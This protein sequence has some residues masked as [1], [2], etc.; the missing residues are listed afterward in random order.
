MD[1]SARQIHFRKW[2]RLSA[3]SVFLQD[4]RFFTANVSSTET[5]MNNISIHHLFFLI[6]G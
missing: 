5:E 6:N 4:H 1:R 2:S 3:E